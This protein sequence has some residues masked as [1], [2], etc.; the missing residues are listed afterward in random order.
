MILSVFVTVLSWFLLTTRLDADT[1]IT[2][3]TEVCE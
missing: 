1:D 2:D 3:S